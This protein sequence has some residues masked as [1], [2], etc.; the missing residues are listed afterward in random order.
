M[1]SLLTFI[2]LLFCSG[3][4]A[5]DQKIYL[6]K[7]DG[8][9]IYTV[10]SLDYICVVSKS[11][12]KDK[13]YKIEEFYNNNKPKLIGESSTLHPYTLQGNCITFFENGKRKS[14]SEYKDG[15]LVNNQ[16]LFYPNGRLYQSLTYS[17]TNKN[18]SLSFQITSASDSLGKPRIIDGTGSYEGY[19]DQFTYVMEKGEIKMGLREGDWTGEDRELKLTF[20]ETYVNGKLLN[21]T[22]TDSLGNTV[23]YKDQRIVVPEYPGGINAFYKALIKYLRYPDLARENNIQGQ[24]EITFNVDVNG[25]LNG[26]RITNSI[27]PILDNESIRAFKLCTNNL[28]PGKMYGR[29]MPMTYHYPVVFTLAEG[30]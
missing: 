10:D 18:D 2:L 11:N 20:K 7:K 15:K 22:S 1:K 21:G 3:A 28:I 17:K 16:F 23:T 30:R 13:L 14:T 27:H 8:T 6:Y 12:P 24:V 19:N 25:A 4:F 9:Q 5:Q 29:V 26:F